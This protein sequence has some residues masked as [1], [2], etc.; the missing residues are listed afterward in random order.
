MISRNFAA[1][2]AKPG[3]AGLPLPGMDLLILDD[4]GKAL[5]TGEMGNLVI[6][7]VPIFPILDHNSLISTIAVSP[8]VRDYVLQEKKLTFSQFYHD[9]VAG[10]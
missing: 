4:N 9:I 7:K 5:S 10:S 8:K 6:R 1:A 2:K 3:S